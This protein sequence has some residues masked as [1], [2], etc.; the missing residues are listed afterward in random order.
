MY[1]IYFNSRKKKLNFCSFGGSECY[2]KEDWRDERA[3][4]KERGGRGREGGGGRGRGRGGGGGEGEFRG[5]ENILTIFK[6]ND[7]DDLDDK[8]DDKDDGGDKDDADDKC[9][10]DI[11]S[12]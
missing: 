11:K 12:H 4:E 8:D 6:K 2:W 3:E 10:S 5:K 1:K 7:E 9:V